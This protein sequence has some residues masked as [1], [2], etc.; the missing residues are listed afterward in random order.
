[1]RQGVR[2]VGFRPTKLSCKVLRVIKMSITMV[3]DKPGGLFQLSA[4]CRIVLQR[5]VTV[6]YMFKL[7][8]AVEFGSQQWII[9][10]LNSLS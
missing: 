5:M 9:S 6:M 8:S 4:T 1:M 10:C 7:R 2:N 3:V